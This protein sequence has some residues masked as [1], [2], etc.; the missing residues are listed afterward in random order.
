MIARP[1]IKNK[2][3]VFRFEVS[4]TGEKQDRRLTIK[5]RNMKPFH[6]CVIEGSRSGSGD[7]R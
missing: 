2:D 6:L 3:D 1:H 4:S 5:E 7:G